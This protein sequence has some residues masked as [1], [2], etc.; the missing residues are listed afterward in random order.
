MKEP[1]QL[2]EVMVIL[3]FRLAQNSFESPVVSRKDLRPTSLVIDILRK[4]GNSL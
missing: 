4:T 3:A 2:R 1:D